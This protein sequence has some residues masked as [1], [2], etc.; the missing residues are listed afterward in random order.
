MQLYDRVAPDA[1]VVRFYSGIA[2]SIVVTVGILGFIR[3]FVRDDHLFGLYQINALHNL[4]HII[5]GL[6]GIFFVFYRRGRF[7][8]VYLLSLGF[9][10]AVLTLF[11][12]VYNGD[13]FDLAYFNLD[14]NL[15][16]AGI[17]VTTLLMTIHIMLAQPELLDSNALAKL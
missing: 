8:L 11:G 2:G 9:L 17:A 12:F 16:H 15:L 7:A 6:P 1:T 3:V 13:F 4:V 10:Y 5:T 14:D